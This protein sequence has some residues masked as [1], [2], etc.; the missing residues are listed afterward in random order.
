MVEEFDVA[1]VGGGAAGLSAAVALGRSLRRVVV[2]DAGEPRNAASPSAHNV[3]GREGLAPRELLARG[4]EEALG[5]GVE[6]HIDRVEAAARSG[7][8]FQLRTANGLT[9][10]SRRLLLATGSRDELPDIPGLA[11]YWGTAVLHCPYCHGWEV[12]GKRLGVI[13]TGPN[14]VHQAQLFRQLSDDVTVVMHRGG[15]LSEDDR[16]GLVARG[17]RI[18]DTPVARVAED[19]SGLAGLVL[20][21]GVELP[22]EALVVASRVEV[23]GALYEQL[24]GNLSDNPMGRHIQTDATGQTELAGVWVAGNAGESSAMIAVATASGL[25]A[26]ARLNADLVQEDIRLALEGM[27]G[28]SG[29]R[30]SR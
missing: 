12:R 30:E 4:R 1:I 5:Y 7:G 27:V 9:L 23:A 17:I 19:E 8:G 2:I 3:L 25:T 15:R 13:A 6:F 29:T 21:D 10:N 28:G 24:G 26:G 16:R 18:V 14:A 11:R 22:F 20:T